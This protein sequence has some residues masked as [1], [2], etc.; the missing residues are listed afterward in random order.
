MP[1]FQKE[2]NEHQYPKKDQAIALPLIHKYEPGKLSERLL[3]RQKNKEN[4]EMGSPIIISRQ[5]MYKS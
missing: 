2:E 4:K 3:W 5:Q 1:T